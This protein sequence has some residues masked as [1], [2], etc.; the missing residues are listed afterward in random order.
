[1]LSAKELLNKG[2]RIELDRTRTLRY[3][4]RAFEEIEDKAEQSGETFDTLMQKFQD[5]KLK[6]TRIFLIAGLRE[7]D[8]NID[9]VD[10]DIL[11]AS[12]EK[13]M[14]S[15]FAIFEALNL[16]YGI[17]T[18]DDEIEEDSEKK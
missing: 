7:D 17:S 10:I 14:E 2:V 6:A 13:I 3:C 18:T 5:G 8:K 16:F 4:F 15:K 12:P 1:M 11:L 9:N